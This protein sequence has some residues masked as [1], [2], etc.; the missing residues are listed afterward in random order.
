MVASLEIL[1]SNYQDSSD[2]FF[3]VQVLSF[4]IYRVFMGWLMFSLC[5]NNGDYLY[6]P[7]ENRTFLDRDMEKVVFSCC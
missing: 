4:H 3:Q 2:C 1:K 6:S 5:L 7:P